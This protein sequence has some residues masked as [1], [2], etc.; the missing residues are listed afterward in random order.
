MKVEVA[1]LGSLSQI[2]GLRVSVDV[3]GRNVELEHRFSE[4]HCLVVTR[5]GALLVA[6]CMRACV[7]VKSTM[8]GLMCLRCTVLLSYVHH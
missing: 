6:A 7:R 8:R 2:V 3:N 1:V 4:P 5:A